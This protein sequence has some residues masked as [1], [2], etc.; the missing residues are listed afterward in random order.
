MRNKLLVLKEDGKRKVKITN[1]GY[2]FELYIMRNGFQ[3]TGQ[4]VDE[5]ILRML[6]EIINEYFGP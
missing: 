2:D 1:N 6:R 4:K 5:K 3:W